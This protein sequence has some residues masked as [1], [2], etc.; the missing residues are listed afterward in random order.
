M[1]LTGTLTSRSKGTSTWRTKRRR[2]TPSV[3]RRDVSSS[4]VSTGFQVGHV[5]VEVG[6]FANND[7]LMPINNPPPPTLSCGT[8]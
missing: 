8:Q 4:P 1:V 7:A 6:S 5:W 3:A 2:T